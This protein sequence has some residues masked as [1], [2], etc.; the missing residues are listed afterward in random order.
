MFAAESYSPNPVKQWVPLLFQAAAAFSFQRSVALTA[1]QAS[2]PLLKL[3]S[4]GI[5]SVNKVLIKNYQL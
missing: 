3:S 1:V 2:H 4:V 5:A